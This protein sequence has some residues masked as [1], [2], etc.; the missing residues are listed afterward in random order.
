LLRKSIPFF[1][2]GVLGVIYY[3]IDTIMLSLMTSTAVVGWYGAGYRIFDTLVFLP[4]L[5]ISAIMYPVFSQLSAHSQSD[6]KIAIEKSLNFLLFCCIPISTGL[7]IAAPNLVGFL[8]HRSD[9]INAIPVMQYLAPGLLFL[10]V[11]S[12]LTSTL[13]SVGREKKIT[14]MAGIALV[15]NLG[16]NL[17]LI[18]LYQQVGAA[19]VT[20][21]T[22]LLLLVVSLFFTP[23]PLWPS[24]SM[25][26]GLKALLAAMVMGVVIW[27]IRQ[28]SFL[29]ILLISAVVYFGVATLI[30]TIPREDVKALYTSIRHKAERGKTS[31][32][33]SDGTQ[34]EMP[35]LTEE[36]MEQEQEFLQVLGREMTNPLL[37]AFK[38]EMTQPLPPIHNN[39]VITAPLPDIS[40]ST[41]GEEMDGQAMTRL[42][43]TPRVAEIEDQDATL[44]LSAVR[45]K[46]R[47]KTRDLTKLAEDKDATLILANVR[48]KMRKETKDLSPTGDASTPKTEEDKNAVVFSSSL[49]KEPKT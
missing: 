28:E 20:S 11:N 15:F 22:E 13:I 7:I 45:P 23:R 9:F 32:E 33:S 26:V 3:R 2:Y 42:P 6:L 48:P 14:L 31:S 24:G 39:S 40:S 41:E 38:Y 29:L 5:V 36:E 4:S 46:A 19:L 37:P 8:Y 21:L 18:P 47:R 16:L 44:L 27:F 35:F 12:V 30:G 25:K 1:V 43:D 10:Y 34:E 17:L 49:S